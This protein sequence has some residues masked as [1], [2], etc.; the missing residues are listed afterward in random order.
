MAE[1]RFILLQPAL[2]Y[3]ERLSAEDRQRIYEAL[4][5]LAK[6]PGNAPI[7]RLH[8]RRE[9]SLRVGGLRILLRVDRPARIFIVVRIGPRGDI[10]KR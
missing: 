8:G 6:D 10:Y 2:S 4:N 3:L 9:F 5:L 7:K 1:W